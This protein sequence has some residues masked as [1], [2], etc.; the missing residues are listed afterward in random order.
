MKLHSLETGNL[1]L[2]GGAMFGVVPKSIWNKQYPADENNLC[3]LSMRVMLIKDAGRTI[4]IDCGMGDK[5][6]ASLQKY[7]FRNGDDTLHSSLAKL[8]VA[9]E[10]VTDVVLTH[11]H[12][13]HCGGAVTETDG[14]LAL[15]FPNAEHW[16]GATQWQA[17]EHP[18]ARERASFFAENF[19]PIQ[20]AGKLR[21]VDGDLQLTDNVRLRQFDGHTE[22]QIIVEILY[23][24][25][26]IVYVADFIPTSAHIPVA[27]VCGYDVSPLITMRETA[28]YLAEALEGGYTF[29]FE[30][31][32]YTECCTL[33][34]GK[35]NAVIGRRL[36][37]D[38]F[39][40]EAE[41]QL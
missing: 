37:L 22:G 3:N 13:D 28:E 39:K 16:V 7:Y 10:E 20:K 33:V 15:M 40:R 36:S 11:L 31:D 29:F 8:G 6:D 5:M 32:I 27:Y 14:E 35:R 23:L 41:M 34:P 12:F 24:G 1:M 38:E 17:A 25:R 2:D 19:L 9:P 30:H 26:K 4:I 18:N 21:L